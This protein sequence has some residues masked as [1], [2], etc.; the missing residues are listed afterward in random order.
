MIGVVLVTHGNLAREF[1][2]A[3]EHIMG[4]QPRFKAI[5]V[6]PTDD[7]ESKKKD[8]TNAVKNVD[9]KQGVLIATDMFGGTPANLAISMMKKGKV[10]VVSGV[11][12]PML[13]KLCSLRREKNKSLKKLTLEVCESGKKYIKDATSVLNKGSK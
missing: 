4:E 6:A 9:D 12:L 10:E 1:L 3:I 7:M 8:I 11:N 2:A 13:I 5:S